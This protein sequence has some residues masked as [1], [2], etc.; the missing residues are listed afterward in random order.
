MAWL[1]MRSSSSRKSAWEKMA[2]STSTSMVCDHFS[3]QNV[4]E[5]SQGSWAENRNRSVSGRRAPKRI[6]REDSAQVSK[7]SRIAVTF[8]MPEKLRMQTETTTPVG[9]RMDE[10][11][12][13]TTSLKNQRIREL[14]ESKRRAYEMMS[15]RQ[16]EQREKT[17]SYAAAI[18]NKTGYLGSLHRAHYVRN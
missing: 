9:H 13:D 6:F 10:W 18:G 14:R 17:M 2:T 11:K 16:M 5:F 15:R 12:A 3:F 8:S 7:R 4:N 1:C